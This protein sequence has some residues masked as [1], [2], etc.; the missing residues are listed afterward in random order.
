MEWLLIAHSIKH[1]LIVLAGTLCIYLGYR[2]FISGVSGE[3]SLHAKKDTSELQLLSAAP[4]V[5][6]A[7]FG[8]GL[9]VADTFWGGATFNATFPARLLLPQ[10]ASGTSTL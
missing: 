9:L 6:F 3:A 10:H 5:F 1:I 2:L 7:L 8:S 4:G